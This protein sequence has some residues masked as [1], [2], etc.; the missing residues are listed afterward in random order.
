[1]T[2]R[3]FNS[4]L[5][6]AIAAAKEARTAIGRL[7]AIVADVPAAG[8]DPNTQLDDASRAAYKLVQ[9]LEAI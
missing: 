3:N 5:E 6:A 9:R 4:I 7:E 2:D 1:M 8:H